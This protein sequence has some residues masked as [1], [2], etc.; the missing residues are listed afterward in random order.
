VAQARQL[1]ARAGRGNLF[2]KIPGT[3]NGIA[4][5]E[6]TIFDGIP[7]NVTLLF[8][9]EHYQA[10]AEAY[11]RAI[12]RRVAA[13]LH[14]FVFSVAS[15]LISRWDKAVMAQ[16][17]RDVRNTLGIAVAQ[18]AYRTYAELARSDR[19][20]RLKKLGAHPQRLMWA[21]TGTRD[22]DASD[23]RY[24]SAL[25]APNT[26]NTLPEQTLL[27]FAD[28]GAVGASLRQDGGD[29][30]ATLARFADDGVDVRALAHTL[31]LEAEQAFNTSWYSLM[32]CIDARIQALSQPV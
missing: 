15:L 12:E 14:P 13:G 26:I 19:W 22:P 21:S 25:T 4:A 16:P 8:S 29:A 30:E 6:E 32:A 2:I 28:H 1:H 23:V 10:A 7:V 9:W 20:Q 24:V 3:A 31:Q 5:I 11:V 17:P 18:R 27:D